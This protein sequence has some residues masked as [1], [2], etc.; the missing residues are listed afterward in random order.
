MHVLVFVLEFAASLIRATDVLI[1]WAAEPVF[2]TPNRSY[3]FHRMPYFN[4]ARSL[5]IEQ[6]DA[7]IDLKSIRTPLTMTHTTHDEVC[8]LCFSFGAGQLNYAVKGRQ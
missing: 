6:R 5:S 8:R 7:A 4:A 3:R 2:G 1:R